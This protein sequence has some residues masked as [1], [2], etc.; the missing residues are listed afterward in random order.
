VLFYACDVRKGG[1]ITKIGGDYAVI[2][3]SL[4]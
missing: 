4:L 2:P 1:G 3:L